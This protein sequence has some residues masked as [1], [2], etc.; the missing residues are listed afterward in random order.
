LKLL[1]KFRAFA[2]FWIAILVMN[3][4]AV[5]FIL[6]YSHTPLAQ[7]APAFALLAGCIAIGAVWHAAA[8]LALSQAGLLDEK[9][10][11]PWGRS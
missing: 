9:R 5:G 8:V 1:R 7:A 6:E 3:F 4:V 2:L 11:G 10:P